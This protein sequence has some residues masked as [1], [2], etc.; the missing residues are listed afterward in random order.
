MTIPDVPERPPRTHVSTKETTMSEQNSTTPALAALAEAVAGLDLAAEQIAAAKRLV[1]AAAAALTEAPAPA[2]VG[3]I[4]AGEHPVEPPAQEVPEGEHP[5]AHPV[6]PEKPGE[7]AH[8]PAPETPVEPETPHAPA[9]GHQPAPEH[10]AEPA[11][12]REPVPAHPADPA[13]GTPHETPPHGEPEPAPAPDPVPVPDPVPTPDPA[14]VPTPP[15]T[16]AFDAFGTT[17]LLAKLAAAK[18]GETVVAK[19][20]YAYEDFRIQGINP[21]SKVRIAGETGARFGKVMIGGSSK[22]SLSGLGFLL[23]A[24]PVAGKA[25][26]FFVDALA[27]CREIEIEGCDFA[28]R[29]DAD[30]YPTWA[31]ADWTDWK[32]GGVNMR[33]PDSRVANNRGRGLNMGFQIGGARSVLEG[34]TL[35]GCSMDAYRITADYGQAIGNSVQ[36]MVAIDGNHPDMLQFFKAGDG[37]LVGLRIRANDFRVAVDIAGNPLMATAQGIGGYGSPKTGGGTVNT[38][39]SD[40]VVEDNAIEC[41][42]WAGMNLTITSGGVVQ[43]NRIA[44]YLK[45]T[46]GHGWL[47][48]AGPCANTVVRDNTAMKL[49]IAAGATQSGNVDL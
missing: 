19:A 49:K 8:A 1:G 29:A 42:A 10:P 38:T 20:G 39:F 47:A 13:P 45:R 23:D 14:P 36:D 21:A 34:N 12:P 3:E 37:Y 22:I 7:P 27:D 44:D 35:F 43:R 32:M 24:K 9:P 26:P 46:D 40:I 48:I 2:P 15:V 30:A 4:P 16:G 41:T 17:E 18:G 25:N 11:P 6:T 28:S 5:A 33:S 31:L